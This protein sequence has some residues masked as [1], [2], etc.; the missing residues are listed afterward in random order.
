MKTA[1]E[2]WKRIYRCVNGPMKYYTYSRMEML[3]LRYT[4]A[5]ERALDAANRRAER[6]EAERDA[7][8][9]AGQK[10]SSEH[11][12]YEFGDGD[13]M[14]TCDYADWCEFDKA[15]GCYVE[16]KPKTIITIGD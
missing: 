5:L 10:F 15:F 12:V 14:P 9:S 2:K 1:Q 16:A 3:D 4:A 7:L 11:W 8:K 6:A 13:N